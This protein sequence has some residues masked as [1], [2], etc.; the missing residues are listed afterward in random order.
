MAMTHDIGFSS[1]FPALAAASP[2]IEKASAAENK[3]THQSGPGAIPNSPIRLASY[4]ECLSPEVV[5]MI[6]DHV[7]LGDPGF[8]GVKTASRYLRNVCTEIYAD[9]LSLMH[10][11]KRS[12]SKETQAE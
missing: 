12:R 11:V 7:P 9:R 10:E 2:S 3:F 4:F 6:M 5:G 8:M 1:S